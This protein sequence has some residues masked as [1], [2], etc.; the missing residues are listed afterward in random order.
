MEMG[1]RSHDFEV[2]AGSFAFSVVR[3][4]YIE[5]KVRGWK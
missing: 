4:Q 3:P 2:P 1:E 5:M